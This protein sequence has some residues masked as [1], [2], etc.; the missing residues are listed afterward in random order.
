VRLS[1]AKIFPRPRAFREGSRP[2]DGILA[3]ELR[4]ADIDFQQGV[5]RAL[6]SGVMVDEP[7][8]DTSRGGDP[9][10]VLLLSFA[11][12]DERVGSSSGL[13]EVEVT[14][15]LADRHREQ[16]RLG[17]KV[18]VVGELTGSGALWANFLAA[19]LPG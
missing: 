6:L 7:Q 17:A 16:L 9:I 13:C 1:P 3:G 12:P 15:K 11:A 14:D 18:L 2:E 10:T 4:F 8:C 19:E 5:N